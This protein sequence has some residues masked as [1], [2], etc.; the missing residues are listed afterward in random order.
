[1]VLPCVIQIRGILTKLSPMRLMLNQIT[2]EPFDAVYV[3]FKSSKHVLK[4]G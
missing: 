1:M 2:E 3:Y 4:I